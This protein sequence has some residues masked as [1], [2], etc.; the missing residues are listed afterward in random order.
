MVKKKNSKH[1][2]YLNPKIFIVIVLFLMAGFATGWL[3]YS[4]A[5]IGC[6]GK[7]PV[8]ANKFAA[9]YSYTVPG[10]KSYSPTVF[11]NYYCDIAA[12]EKA[13]YHPAP[14]TELFKKRNQEVLNQN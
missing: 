9:A 6:G 4:I 5:Y 2:N 13:G 8:I 10:D 11:S 3:Q 12:A 7:Q 14:G 1:K